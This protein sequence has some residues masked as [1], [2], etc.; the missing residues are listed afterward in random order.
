MREDLLT[1]DRVKLLTGD[2]ERLYTRLLLVVDDFGLCDGRPEVI[3]AKAFALHKN[4]TDEMI[5][6]WVDAIVGAQLAERYAV[7]GKQY[8][9]IFNTRQRRRANTPKFPL[10][11]ALVGD[12][13]ADDGQLTDTGQSGDGLPRPR[14]YAK[15]ES[16]AKA[17][18]KK[19]VLPPLNPRPDFLPSEFEQFESERRKNGSPMTELARDK[20]V[21]Q[22]GEWKLQGYDITA[23]LNESIQGG[24]TGVFAKPKHKLRG[25]VA[26]PSRGAIEAFLAK[27]DG[28]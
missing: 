2:E 27:T 8:L 7:A 1:S 3:R 5:P 24:W 12:A 19:G 16:K 10:P 4:V 22:L 28:K 23:I 17:G 6:L 14:A 13:R 20:I 9:H 26:A 11:P 21:R 15:A 25:G 18:I